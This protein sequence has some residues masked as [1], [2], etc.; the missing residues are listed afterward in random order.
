MYIDQV[1]LGIKTFLT[2][3]LKLLVYF[4]LLHHLYF[5]LT[6]FVFFSGCDLLS[7]AINYYCNFINSC[8]NLIINID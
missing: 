6:L 1:I 3:T 5:L 4:E 2:L 8:S 7:V